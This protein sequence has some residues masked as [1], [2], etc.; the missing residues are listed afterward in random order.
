MSQCDLKLNLTEVSSLPTE[1]SKT[2]YQALGRKQL[3]FRKL[4][5]PGKK[6]RSL[7]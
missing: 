5:P 7:V 3:Y 2:V 4:V 6:G 1:L